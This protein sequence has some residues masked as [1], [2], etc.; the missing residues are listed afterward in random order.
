MVTIRSPGREPRH[1]AGR[2]AARG[3]ARLHLHLAAIRLTGVG[4]LGASVLRLGSRVTPG[5]LAKLV[6]LVAFAAILVLLAAE[7]AVAAGKTRA[8]ASLLAAINAAR[9]LYGLAPLRLDPAL[10]DAAHAHTLDMLRRDYFGHGD[11]SD[12]MI[13]FH[14]VGRAV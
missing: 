11:F 7:S 9:H 14:A 6:V 2:H 12:R 10:T 4:R 1:H 13:R 5:L 3:R 8:A